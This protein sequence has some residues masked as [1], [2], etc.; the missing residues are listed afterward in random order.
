[1][2]NKGFYKNET[3][4]TR[5]FKNLT[6][7]LDLNKNNE[8]TLF[9]LPLY[10]SNTSKLLSLSLVYN[11]LDSSPS[12]CND[13]SHNYH[14]YISNVT[15]QS[16]SL[17]FF[18]GNTYVF[19]ASNGKF[20]NDELDAEISNVGIIFY[21]LKMSGYKSIK[22]ITNGPVF[23]LFQIESYDETLTFGYDSDGKITTI[24]SDA[25]NSESITFT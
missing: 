6:I 15:S 23:I 10:T 5:K 22:Y 2:S 18:G 14:S 8:N 16:L 17:R 24:Q 13:L 7:C 4:F 11:K 3:F 9:V 20:V 1:M 25:F 19:R 12:F 21:E